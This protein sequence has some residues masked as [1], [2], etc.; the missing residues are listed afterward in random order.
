[1]DKEEVSQVLAAGVELEGVI[2]GTEKE[3]RERSKS[4]YGQE[5]LDA[6]LIIFGACT[7][8]LRSYSGV[9]GK[10][11]QSVSDRLTLISVALQGASATETL[12]SEG[13]YAKGAAAL[14]QDMEV[15]VRIHETVAGVA[16][17]G[18]TPQLKYLPTAGA[19][20]FYGELNDVAHPSNIGRLRELLALAEPAGGAAGV[21]PVPEFRPAVAIP[22]YQLHVYLL[23]ETSL[24]LI[25]LMAEMYSVDD[26]PIQTASRLII[27]V[28]DKPA[29]QSTSPHS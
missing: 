27:Y 23:F 29:S 11:D 6:R 24:E 19:R 13:Q 25:K 20:R 5:L 10:T 4:A 8:L 26:A 9:P 2:F 15:V 18:T 16:K 17:A 3:I 1:M 12:I 22:L 28:R 21:S 14:K 7:L